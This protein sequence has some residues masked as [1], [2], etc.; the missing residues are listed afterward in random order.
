MI[1]PEL[2]TAVKSHLFTLGT[3]YS[4]VRFFPLSAYETT[5]APFIVYN[6]YFGTQ[7]EEQFFLKISNVIYTIYDNDISR[8]KDIA[9]YIE[10]FLNVG[11][12]IEDIKSL[13]DPPYYSYY[14]DSSTRFRITTCRLVSGGLTPPVERE[15]F[16]A[17]Q[18]N[19]RVV[20]L[21]E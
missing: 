12:M 8:M 15:G 14:G 17:Y 10:K 11:D 6:E 21:H 3:P 5:Q 9:Y 18:L 7:N 13:I 4:T 19:F 1:S 16:A 2:N 20:Y